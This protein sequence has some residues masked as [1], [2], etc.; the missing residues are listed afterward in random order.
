MSTCGKL[1]AQLSTSKPRAPAAKPPVYATTASHQC[2]Q[3]QAIKNPS[4]ESRSAPRRH[5]ETRPPE[6]GSS[7]AVSKIPADLI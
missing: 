4:L 5:A 1:G 6:E 2:E 3:E 7:A